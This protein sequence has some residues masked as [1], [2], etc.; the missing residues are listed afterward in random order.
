MVQNLLMLLLFTNA[1]YGLLAPLKFYRV[2]VTFICGEQSGVGN[3][4]TTNWFIG[5][6]IQVNS[7]TFNSTNVTILVKNNFEL[8]PRLG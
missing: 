8:I 5:K 3:F 7:S 6:D 2:Q 4:E 1:F